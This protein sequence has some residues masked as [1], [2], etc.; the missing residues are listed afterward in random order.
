MN[1][2]VAGVAEIVLL[3]GREEVGCVLNEKKPS[4]TAVVETVL[5]HTEVAGL[6]SASLA[7]LP[8]LSEVL[9]IPAHRHHAKRHAWHLLDF[10]VMT[11][12]FR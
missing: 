9:T 5:V 8:H 1:V 7:S 4:L 12:K 10:G 2:T 11:H 6:T 3:D